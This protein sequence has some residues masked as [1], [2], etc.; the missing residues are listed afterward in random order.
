MREGIYEEDVLREIG[1]RRPNGEKPVKVVFDTQKA[2]PYR[3]I[4]FSIS[5]DD[6]R[7]K[8]AAAL[9]GL[10]FRWRFPDE[11]TE[12]GTK[13][14]HYFQGDER[15]VTK[16]EDGTPQEE[17]PA[18]RRWKKKKKLGLMGPK[19]IDIAIAVHSQRDMT[20]TD[21]LEGAI[22][23]LRSRGRQATGAFAETLRFLIAFGVALAGLEAGALDQLSKLDFFPATIAVVALGFGAD[24]IKNLLT[25]APKK[26]S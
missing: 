8:G 13:V 11:M 14:C 17:K 22:E 3:P 21:T 16:I 7:F 12:E 19:R 2:R 4:Y 6:P 24:S 23:L 25:Q 26:A 1:K 9:N 20:A 5:F 10:T 18:E 15:R